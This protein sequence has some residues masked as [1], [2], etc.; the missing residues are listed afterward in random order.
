MVWIP[1]LN[2]FSIWYRWTSL[3]RVVVLLNAVALVV[4]LFTGKLL[5]SLAT[6]W[7][8]GLE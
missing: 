6:R 2:S 4:Y 5:R 7:R 3:T 8:V 1:N